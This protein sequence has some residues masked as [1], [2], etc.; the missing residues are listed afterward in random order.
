MK[1]HFTFHILIGFHNNHIENC[2]LRINFASKYE[3]F[4]FRNF[5]NVDDQNFN[6][7]LNL[8]F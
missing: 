6:T 7:N 1:F 8:I 2:L 4:E 3:N 5:L